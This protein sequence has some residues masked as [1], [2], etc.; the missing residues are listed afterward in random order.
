MMSKIRILT[1][2]IV[3]LCV[4]GLV[5]A[6][7]TRM[8]VQFTHPAITPRIQLEED[9]PLPGAFP[10]AYRTAQD[11][12]A[13]G[14]ATAFDH[15]DFMGLDPQTHLL[16]IAHTGPAPDREQQ[17]NPKFNMNTDAKYDGNVVIFN[18]V[19]KKVVGLLPIPQV[20]GVVVAPDLHKVY[21]ADSYD[22][23]IYAIDEHT[24]KFWPIALQNNDS[25]D[26]LAY[27]PDDHLVF[28]SNPGT[29]PSL[30]TNIIERKNQ[31]ETIID[32]LTDKVVARIEL[33]VDGQWGDDVGLV[34]Y[35]AGLRRAYVVVQQLPDP[36]SPNQNILPP[37]GTAWL[38]EI[39][40]VT[41]SIVTRMHLPYNCLTPHGVAFD[42]DQHIAFIAC[43]DEDPP[44]LIRV[45]LA[46]MTNFAEQP[47]PVAL[48]PDVI[49]L[50]TQ[51]HLVYVGS[52]AGITIFQENGRSLKW[53]AT[54]T[55]GMSTH[56]LMVNQQT[57]EVY[58][59]LA[60]EG[61]RPVLRIMRYDPA[62]T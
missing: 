28:V 4:V 57:H 37:P 43:I 41:R 54:Y 5:F 8:A 14:V 13:P 47:W 6:V 32:A 39:N 27:D 21:V 46:T 51:Y 52:G 1:L 61:N 45:D 12:L 62:G 53:L 49:I 48:K 11:P 35:D 20:A 34:K 44:S 55:Y 42:T 30:D 31:N 38:V 24:L 2:G 25:P 7:L 36:N 10:D 3:T 9:I 56:S 26:T 59:P 16:F 15:F 60:K 19:E 40:P 22:N 58:L 23:I 50:D 18:V 33:G 29:P 17:I